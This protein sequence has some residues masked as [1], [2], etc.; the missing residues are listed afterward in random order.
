[1]PCERRRAKIVA[2]SS[3]ISAGY[4]LIGALLVC[5]VCVVHACLSDLFRRLT[6][7]DVLGTLSLS[8]TSPARGWDGIFWGVY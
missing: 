3:F 8:H 7:A 5:V 1:M 4:R 6:A 2:G